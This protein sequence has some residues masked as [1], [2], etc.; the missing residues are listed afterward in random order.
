MGIIEEP[1][2]TLISLN[3]TMTSSVA[4]DDDSKEKEKAS[5]W[6]SEDLGSDS[7]IS[8]LHHEGEMSLDSPARTGSD[9]SGADETGF[10]AEKDQLIL[11]TG[12]RFI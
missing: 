12:M 9:R 11:T 8:F 1:D 4:T 6:E 2:L 10:L 7:L 5:Q 3:T